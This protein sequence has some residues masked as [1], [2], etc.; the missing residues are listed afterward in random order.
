L[1]IFSSCGLDLQTSSIQLSCLT[2]VLLTDL[3]LRTKAMFS[4]LT[5]LTTASFLRALVLMSCAIIGANTHYTVN[6]GCILGEKAKT[7]KKA[8]IP[9]HC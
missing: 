7:K 3:L 9:R 5:H 4:S 6:D 1:S 8:A 2:G